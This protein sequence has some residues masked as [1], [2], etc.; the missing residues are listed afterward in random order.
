MSADDQNI[1]RM[2]AGRYRLDAILGRGGFGSVY[3]G[4]DTEIGRDVAVKLL[5]VASSARTP[6]QTEELRERFRREA[7][8]AGRINHPG[9]V[10][11]FDFGIPEGSE[12]YLVMELLEG[13]DLAYE[14]DNR[15]PLLPDRAVRLFVPLLEALGRG[16]ELG[17]VHKD[18][19]PQNVF[20]R[21]PGAK[22]ESLCVVDFGVARVIHEDKLTMTGLL[23][24][25]P[26]YMAPEYITDTTVT[27]ALDVYQMGLILAESIT[28][29][30]AVPLDETFVRSCNRHFTGDLD[31]PDE[32]YEG[33]FGEVLAGA[34]APNPVDRIVDATA[35][36][37][38]LAG[39][40]PRTIVLDSTE[41]QLFTRKDR[42]VS[43]FAEPPLY[44]PMSPEKASR[45]LERDEQQRRD[46]SASLS[47]REA[48]PVPTRPSTGADVDPYG[49]TVW[50]DDGIKA[51][52]VPE[53]ALAA[54]DGAVANAAP[55]PGPASAV[56][57]GGVPSAK[58]PGQLETRDEQWEWGEHQ[59]TEETNPSSVQRGDMPLTL[60]VAIIA[61]LFAVGAGFFAYRQWGRVTTP[62]Q[63]G[64]PTADAPREAT[65]EANEAN[66]EAA[67]APRVLTLSTTPSGAAIFAGD[68]R[69]GETPTSIT[70]DEY[71][72]S[73]FELR[74]DGYEPRQ[75]A[76]EPGERA[77]TLEKVTPPAADKKPSKAKRR[78]KRPKRRRPKSTRSQAT[79]TPS[80]E[81]QL[82]MDAALKGLEEQAEERSD[83]PEPRDESEPNEEPAAKKDDAAPQKREPETWESKRVLKKKPTVE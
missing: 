53:P 37:K 83:E 59:L 20:L 6:H 17:I 70:L 61:L 18:I 55:E 21:N 68:R 33:P 14:L 66:E 30:P 25:T 72:S 58:L 16:H 51:I 43:T 45:E 40:D 75:V 35:F 5:D 12:A 80:P 78:R 67:P 79:A 44:P 81:Q 82:K 74:L 31:I 24:G 27:P 8:A 71:E 64:A 42:R 3:R 10:T 2:V 46:P 41:T 9:I 50:P 36:M 69:V 60:I 23:V 47:R 54:V 77:V 56:G 34:L 19:K 38:A 26:Q 52:Q 7:M 28:G 76:A 39:V 49:E 62:Q 29:V 65:D 4:W 32:L 11:I 48:T 15:G 63:E 13:H 73:K 22:G 57:R 1:G